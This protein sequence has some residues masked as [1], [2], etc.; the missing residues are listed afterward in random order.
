VRPPRAPCRAPCPPRHPSS[1]AARRVR[2]DAGSVGWLLEMGAYL[3]CPI[4]TSACC[5]VGMW[6]V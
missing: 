6:T 1:P 4:L 3:E 2:V 5:Q